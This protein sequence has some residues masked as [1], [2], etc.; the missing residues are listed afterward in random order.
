M[1]VR[2]TCADWSRQFDPVQDP[3]LKGKK[4]SDTGFNITIAKRNVGPS[5]TQLYMV[6]TMLESLIADKSGGKR[7]LR[8]DIDGQYL[9]LIDQFHKTSFY[10]NYLLSFSGKYEIKKWVAEL[11]LNI[12]LLTTPQMFIQ[13]LTG[14]SIPSKVLSMRIISLFFVPNCEIAEL[15]SYKSCQVSICIHD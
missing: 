12:V 3:V 8:K 14:F 4:D 7:T 5:S 10:W 1:S 6:R 2:E 15:N 9:M 11:K 13:P